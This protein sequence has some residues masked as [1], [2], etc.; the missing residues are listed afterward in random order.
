MAECYGLLE[1]L[2]GGEMAAESFDVVRYER[3]ETLD[4]RGGEVGI[5]GAAERA[6]TRMGAGVLDIFWSSARSL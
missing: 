6:V 4:G 1:G 5:E 3:F 2:S